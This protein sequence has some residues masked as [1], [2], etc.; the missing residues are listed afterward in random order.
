MTNRNRGEVSVI[1]KDKKYIL[2]PSFQIL[3]SI[4]EEIGRS[5]INILS[6]LS[7]KK[8]Q[9]SEIVIIVKYGISF[10]DKNYHTNVDLGELIFN[11]GV[12]KI[13]PKVIEFLW[14]RFCSELLKQSK[15]LNASKRS[16]L[17]EF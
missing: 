3:C 17:F 12:V 11:S 5:I 2:R 14:L 10:Y 15:D 8:I 13:L 16:S 6:D 9:L 4:E 7:E 1:L